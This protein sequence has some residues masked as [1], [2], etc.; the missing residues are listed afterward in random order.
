VERSGLGIEAARPNAEAELDAARAAIKRGDY[1]AAIP[2][3]R[4]LR[5]TSL[6]AE[7]DYGLGWVAKERDQLDVADRHF[8]RAL[9][10]DSRHAHSYWQL[11][12]LALRR[13]SSSEAQTLFQMALQAQPGHAAALQE[14]A[15]MGVTPP[16]TT[17]PLPSG[18]PGGS[19]DGWRTVADAPA[20]PGVASDDEFDGPFGVYEYLRKDRSALSRQAVAVLDR[21]Y[22]EKYPPTYLSFFTFGLPTAQSFGKAFQYGLTALIA[23]VVL[24]AV[25]SFLLAP[26]QVPGRP[27]VDSLT[28]FRQLTSSFL[29]FL[30]G[31]V[32]WAYVAVVVLVLGRFL[33]HITTRIRIERGRLQVERGLLTRTKTNLELWRVQNIVLERRGLNLLTGDGTLVFYGTTGTPPEKVTG[34]TRGRDLERLHEEL[35]DLVFLLRTNPSIKGIVQ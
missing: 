14:L 13:D 21:L 3:F 31:L 8:R 15:K 17:Q 22:V 34:V 25:G 6:E 27:A 29:Q 1:D 4:R 20:P 12:K 33:R 23:I 30:T 2:H 7:G 10:F 24:G 35:L 26:A 16:P 11:G 18:P 32:F 5:G 19:T 9:E 28:A